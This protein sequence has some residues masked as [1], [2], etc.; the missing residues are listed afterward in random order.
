MQSASAKGRA[1]TLAALMAI[2]LTAVNVASCG[3][4]NDEAL[5]IPVSTSAPLPSLVEV[6]L[7]LDAADLPDLEPTTVALTATGYFSYVLPRGE[8]ELAVIV[9]SL[10]EVAA[11]WGRRGEGPG[12]ARR[13]YLLAGDSFFVFVASDPASVLVVDVEGKLVHQR[14]AALH[15]G[16][17][18]AV[19]GD[20]VDRSL[21][22]RIVGVR[23]VTT[24]FSG[25]ILRDCLLESCRR[26]LLPASDSILRLVHL[27]TPRREGLRWPPYAAE[28]GRFVI[29]DGVDYRLWYFDENGQLLGAMQ[30]DIPRRTRTA[31]ERENDEASWARLIEDGIQVD[32]EARRA[33]ADTEPL[34][35]FAYASLGFDAEHRLWVIGKTGDST[36]ADVFAD[37][38]FLGRRLIDCTRPD[39][40]P[41]S[42]RGRFLV[43][44]CSED[45]LES[46][47]RFRLFKI[48]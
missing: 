40:G 19:V 12:E 20:S 26:E 44:T 32:I 13:G 41:A 42:V 38:T 31:R 5:D 25:P 7:A 23:G 17:P 6:P 47:Y 24:D 8:S 2:V 14:I 29:G 16:F 37:T 18:G 46:P 4:S 15:D 9:D 3:D 28:Q 22:Q 21:G 34:P 39:R 1:P 33:L 35:H 48:Q 36:F 43:L 11:R 45:N 27:S 10:G 30:R